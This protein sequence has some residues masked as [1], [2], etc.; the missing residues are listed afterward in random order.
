[1]NII[2]LSPYPAYKLT[3]TLE[4][5]LFAI[6]VRWRE[7]QAMWFVDVECEELGLAVKGLRLV[8]GFDLLSGRGEYRLGKLVLLDLEANADPDFD[9]LGDRWVLVYFTLAEVNG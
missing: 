3:V 6:R 5:R 4:G 1:M 2:P 9:R 7:R 8:T